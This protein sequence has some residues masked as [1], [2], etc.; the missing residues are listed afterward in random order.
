MCI[1]L[2]QSSRRG[3]EQVH[4]LKDRVWP[5][6]GGGTSGPRPCAGSLFTLERRAVIV[7]LSRGISRSWEDVSKAL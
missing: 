5:S 3:G 7:P 2:E 6:P 4:S 1:L